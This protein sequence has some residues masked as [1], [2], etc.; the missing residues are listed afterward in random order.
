MM[1][2]AN[3]DKSEVNRKSLAELRNELKRWEEERM[4]PKRIIE[5]TTAHEVSPLV[6]S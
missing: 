5:D 6:L 3:L 4:R 2:N 1:N